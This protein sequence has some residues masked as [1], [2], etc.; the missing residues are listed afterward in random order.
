MSTLTQKRT[1]TPLNLT[2][3]PIEILLGIPSHLC[4]APVPCHEYRVLSSTHLER[5]ETLRALSATCWHLR[6][7]FLPLAWAHI[8]IC[9][10]RKVSH[11]YV[12]GGLHYT[13]RMGLAL[14]SSDLATDFWQ[15]LVQKMTLVTRRRPDLASYVRTV[16]VVLSG[17]EI[18]S[19]VRGLALLPNLSTIQVLWSPSSVLEKTLRTALEPYTFHGIRTLVLHVQA[20]GL[21]ASC[22]NLLHLTVYAH[23]NR[24]SRVSELP[25]YAPKLR[26][27][28]CLPLNAPL[29]QDLV[30]LLPNLVEIPPIRTKDLTVNILAVLK[31]M[32]SLSRIDLVEDYGRPPADEPLPAMKQLIIAAKELLGGGPVR[33]FRQFESPLSQ[34][35]PVGSGTMVFWRSF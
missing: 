27:F 31:N 18:H 2:A 12:Y 16:T 1:P 24:I 33:L 3:L 23:W 22:P 30:E 9:A 32:K 17:P 11:A 4:G 6:T 25:E 26:T 13:R 35:N 21:M 7:V 20:F 19:F 29:I 34:M 8:E 14:W 28:E 10:S 5:A 15:E